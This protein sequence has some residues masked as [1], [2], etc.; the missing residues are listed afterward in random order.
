MLR[1]NFLEKK[2]TFV[3]KLLKPDVILAVLLALALA[4]GLSWYTGQLKMQEATLKQENARLDKELAR[5]KKIQREEKRLIKT[6]ETLQKKLQV[7][8]ELDRKRDVPQ[9]IYFFADRKNVPY[10]VWLTG[11]RQSGDNIFI[12]GGAYN[13][14]LVSTFLKNIEQGLGSVKFRQTSYEEYKSKDTG[15][16]YHYYKFQFNVEMK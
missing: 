8:S 16:T 11:L 9:Y 13:L 4:G 14:K 15:K 1:F 6:R 7:I 5:L 12:E 10:G 3:E 2:E